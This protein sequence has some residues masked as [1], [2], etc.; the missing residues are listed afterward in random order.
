M[1]SLKKQ[2][3]NTYHISLK[4]SSLMVLELF[5]INDQH[6]AY[7]RTTILSSYTFHSIPFD[8]MRL[9]VFDFGWRQQYEN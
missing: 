8:S 9:F 6:T 2:M 7:R 4:N 3:P 1:F 5:L